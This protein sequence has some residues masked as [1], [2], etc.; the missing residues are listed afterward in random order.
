MVDDTDTLALD[1][2]SEV[3]RDLFADAL[4][5]PLTDP[6][7]SVIIPMFNAE[8]TIA[9][10]L[11]ALAGQTT[12]CWWE[13]IVANNRSTD[14][15]V[16]IVESF[17]G[18]IPRLRV[19]QAMQRQGAG[20]AL[21]RGVEVA[22]GSLLLFCDADDVA[23]PDWI[24]AMVEALGQRQFVASRH[25]TG[26]LNPEW[27]ANA[28]QNLQRESLIPYRHPHY[29][30]HAGGA[31][32][33]VRRSAH[34]AVGG[35]DESWDCLQDTDY[36]WRLQ[37]HGVSLN[38]VPDAVMHVRY[39]P[40]LPSTFRQALRWGEYNVQLYKRYRDRGMPKLTLQDGLKTVKSLLR[41]G[42]LRSRKGRA[43]TVWK[44]G[45][46]LGRIRGSLKN[47]VISL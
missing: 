29:L 31:G 9:D 43:T 40:D 18:R 46:L 12:S 36:C 42:R 5:A 16:E 28:R 2:P 10:Q 41:P 21:N 45:W 38:F 6:K 1:Q 15:S 13:L 7:V 32:L 37:L 14:R 23:A 17:R 11:D 44:L 8:A 33:G 24:D 20:Y 26:Q 3:G 27:L 39:R 25:E 19:I 34:E 35:F 22:Q 4:A 30:P 47:G